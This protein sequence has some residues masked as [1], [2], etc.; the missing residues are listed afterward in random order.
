MSEAE[1]LAEAIR[2]LHTRPNG[3]KRMTAYGKHWERQLGEFFAIPEFIAFRDAN[4]TEPASAPVPME[5][6]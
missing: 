5:K 3:P 4:A 6:P 2:L 1:L